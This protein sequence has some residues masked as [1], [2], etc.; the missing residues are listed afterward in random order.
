M[1]ARTRAGTMSRNT[2]A[3]GRLV[4]G[5]ALAVAGLLTS[6][7]YGADWYDG[8]WRSRQP[9]TVLSQLAAQSGAL[10]GAFQRRMESMASARS[11]P[12]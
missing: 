8:A 1:K 9:E 11:G 12:P 10:S 5:L 3:G 2:D 7:G 4:L 6:G